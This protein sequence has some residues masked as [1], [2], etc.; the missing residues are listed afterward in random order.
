MGRLIDLDYRYQ[1]RRRPPRTALAPWRP[2]KAPRTVLGLLLKYRYL[3]RELLEPLYARERGG[4]GEGEVRNHLTRLY[5]Y[6]YVERFFRPTEHGLGS[7]QYVYTVTGEGAREVLGAEEWEQAQWRIRKLLRHRRDYEH[8]LAV[9]LFHVLW[10]LGCEEKPARDG[11]RTELYWQDREGEGSPRDPMNR[12]EVRVGGKRI[13]IDPDTTVLLGVFHP[14]PG[15][16]RP[17]F[18]EIERTHK[19][20]ERLQRRFR[21][22]RELVAGQSRA[23]D[24][25]FGKALGKD[26]FRAEEGSVLFIAADQ[27]HRDQLRQ[28]AHE[29]VGFSAKHGPDFWFLTLSDLF[30]VRIEGDLRTGDQREISNLIP[31]AEL[32]T[33]RHAVRLD[34]KAITIPLDWRKPERVV[35]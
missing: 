23:A 14:E 12:F 2:G 19:N 3:T 25:V 20:R 31:S 27:R 18:V 26:R 8:P 35:S 9:S 24:A 30:D 22:Y 21:A 29:T 34:G 16:Y 1:R 7:R 5:R 15:F 4:K 11:F 6:G 10:N 33:R 17:L 28:V 13:R 32:F